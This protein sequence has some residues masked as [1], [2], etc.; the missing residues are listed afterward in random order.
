M[1]DSGST[2]AIIS[3]DGLLLD[4]GVCGVLTSMEGDSDGGGGVSGTAVGSD[5]AGS[6]D[7]RQPLI[8]PALNNAKKTTMVIV[9]FTE[10][11]SLVLSIRQ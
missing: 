8:R 2:L 9:G 7:T 5:G 10:N 4:S 1:S 11:V 6:C 3:L